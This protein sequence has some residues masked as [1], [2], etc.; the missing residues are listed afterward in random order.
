MRPGGR[1]AA[2]IDV[3]QVVL[4]HHQPASRALK[5][6]ARDHRFAGSGDRSAIGNLVFD[7]LR[8]R[9]SLSHR[10]GSDTPRALILAAAR[11]TWPMGEAGFA[12]AME[13][14]H[15]PG[16][17]SADE[18]GRLAAR[19]ESPE[20][21]VHVAGDI[22]QWLVASFE[23]AFGDRAPIEGAA[24]AE[25]AP[26]DLRTNTLKAPRDKCL[27]ALAK[28][29]AVPGPLSPL[30]IRLAAPRGDERAPNV[31]AEAGFQR[32]WFEIQDA[33]SQVAALLVGAQA[34]M[35]VMDLCAGGGGKTLAMA[36]AMHNRGQ[37]HAHDRDRQRLKPIY[38][39]LQ[40]AGVRNA[41]VVPA[42][43]PERLARLA[44]HLDRV[45]IDAPCSGS[46]SWRR[47][48]DAKW[49]LSDR[50]LALRCAEQAALL[51]QAADLVKP[52]GRLAYVTCSLL[53][54]ENHD[55]IAA[56][57]QRRSDYVGLDMG[58]VWRETIGTEL[59][60]DAAGAGTV[61]LTPARHATDGFFIAVLAR[62]PA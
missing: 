52:G 36:A 40:R 31:E 49:R 57:R 24:L 34:E 50:Q 23:R 43:E 19:A 42:D 54:E 56:F 59:P 27:K 12:A 62:Q 29:A 14:E 18:A 60:G 9:N 39:R 44:G 1:A 8:R 58:E 30:A 11:E 13:E 46:G 33:G 61:T 32:G 45:L 26:I 35:Q 4:E 10:M 25:R 20:L 41:Q 21:P 22:P 28:F 7:A 51:D 3:L 38:E 17:L 48:P 53:P 55:Q 6:W 37:I 5:D 15:G 16:A 47:K 2:A